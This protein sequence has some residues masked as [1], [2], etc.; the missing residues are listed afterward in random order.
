MCTLCVHCVFTLTVQCCLVQKEVETRLPASVWNQWHRRV[1]SSGAPLNMAHFND[2]W[3]DGVVAPAV[4]CAGFSS[5]LLLE[6][7]LTVLLSPTF[8][9]I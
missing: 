7:H 4:T 9:C 8:T 5:W 3:V 1:P 6:C 2:E